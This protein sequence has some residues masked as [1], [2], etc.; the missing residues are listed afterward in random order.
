MKKLILITLA[1]IIAPSLFAQK[2]AKDTLK[3]DEV[4]VVK[5]YTPKIADAFKIK[6]RPSIEKQDAKKEKVEYT[7]H[8]FPVASTFTPIMGTAKRVA[9]A[10]KEKVYENYAAGGVGNF[11]ALYLEAFVHKSSNEFNDFGGRIKHLSSSGGIND[12]LVDD[13]YSGTNM[14][15]YYKQLTRDYDW[16][17]KGGVGSNR[18]NWYGLPKDISYTPAFLK[19]LDVEQKYLNLYT[20]GAILFIDRDF[21][22]IEI[23]VNRFSDNYD[24]SEFHVVADAKVDLEVAYTLFDSDASIEYLSSKF[25][26]DYDNNPGTKYS[27]VNLGF[28]PNY[29]IEQDYLSVNIGAKIYYSHDLSLEKN[30]LYLYPNITVSYKMMEKYLV[31]VGGVTGDFTQNTYQNFAKENPFISPTISLAQT[32]EQYNVYAGLKGKLISKISYN[33]T[34]SYRNEKDKALFV[35][36]VSKTNGAARPVYK[37]Q[38]GNSFDVVYDDVNTLNVLGGINVDLTEEFK[39]GGE[40]EFNNYSATNQ[41]EAWN[42]P[43]ISSTLF[44][45]YHTKKWYAGTDIYMVGNRKDL[46]TPFGGVPIVKELSTYVDVNLNGGYLFTDKITAFIKFNNVLSNNYERYSNFEVQGFQVLVGALYKFDM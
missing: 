1:L 28:M 5:P 22:N 8:S 41:Q 6:D 12:V 37:Y 32:N 31:L 40:V 36:N 26:R 39:F 34:A 25:E 44:G 35:S 46:I 4:I 9:K 7:F 10:A 13:G 14:D 18:Q 2:L 24:S 43:T 20:S 33:L 21:K 29:K 42:L 45:N 38:A 27:Y 23:G 19:G 30:H 16:E 3:I 11:A 15:L 17:I